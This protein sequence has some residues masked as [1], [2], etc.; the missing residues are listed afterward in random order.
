MSASQLHYAWR[1]DTG[2]VRTHN[3]DAVGVDPDLGL[4]VVAD[5]I[6]GAWAGEVASRLAVDTILA[7]LR[8]HTLA[9]TD[10]DNL[11]S[12][13]AWLAG[14]ANREV[15]QRSRSDPAYAGMGTTVVM[16]ITG[17]DWLAYANV[18]DSRLY[19]LRCGCLEQLSHDHSH[20]QEQV[21]RGDYRT[22]EDARLAGI[23]GHILTRALGSSPEVPVYSGV[24][25]L[26]TGDLYLF[27]TDGLT[28]MVSEARL[29]QSLSAFGGSGL[30]SVADSLVDLANVYGGVD[31]IT[32]ALLWV[33]ER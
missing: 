10:T 6:G 33:G 9:A 12:L 4:V 21:D 30:E 16:G 8:H 25:D 2:C 31:N 18:G 3:E 7:R 11:R 32:L 26:Q 13:T 17:R 15:W 27:C 22:R 24:T 19:R 28:D 5:G 29:H 20:V 1:T 14:E 23:G